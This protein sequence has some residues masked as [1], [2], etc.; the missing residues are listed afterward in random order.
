M[1]QT[2]PSPLRRFASLAGGVLSLVFL[3]VVAVVV[4]GLGSRT[5]VPDASPSPAIAVVGAG[6]STEPVDRSDGPT[7]AASASPTG[8]PTPLPTTGPTATPTPDPTP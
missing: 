4:A 7:E 3:V 1:T 6:A 2:S 5:A 8:E